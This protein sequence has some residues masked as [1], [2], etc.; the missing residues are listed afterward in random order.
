LSLCRFD[1]VTVEGPAVADY[2]AELR[3]RWAAV[4]DP[5]ARQ[6]TPGQWL[7]AL[8]DLDEAVQSLLPWPLPAPRSWWGRWRQ[9]AREAVREARKLVAH[10]AQIQLLAGPYAP[11]PARASHSP[12]RDLRTAGQ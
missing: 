11:G 8:L 3:R 6:R 9:R 10:P 5:G 12:R 7:K 2:Q 4:A 1:I